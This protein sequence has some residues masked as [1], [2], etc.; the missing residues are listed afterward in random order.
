MEEEE[1]RLRVFVDF[2]QRLRSATEMVNTNG[3]ATA[4]KQSPRSATA[5]VNAND[6][7]LAL[8]AEKKIALLIIIIQSKSR[9]D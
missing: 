5:V 7:A 8:K 4:F 3:W 1:L 6:W 2:K 9:G